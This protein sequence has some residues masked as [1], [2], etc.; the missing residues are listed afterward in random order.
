MEMA[1]TYF[2]LLTAVS[3]CICTNN[4]FAQSLWQDQENT[5]AARALEVT[6]YVNKAR[7]LR[8][9]HEAM[10]SLLL[11]TD[12]DNNIQ[13]RG[14]NSLSVE[15]PLPDGR[16][17]ILALEK[18]NLLPQELASS[19]P[20]ISTYKVAKATGDIISG[21]IDFTNKGF[22]AL[23]QTKDGETLLIDPETTGDLGQYLSYRKT[24][25][26]NHTPHQC[27][28]PA[29]QHPIQFSSLQKLTNVAAR[30]HSHSLTEYKIAI[31]ATAEYTQAQGGSVEDALSAIVTTLSRVNHIY[32]QS[33]GVRFRLVE[34]N[35][36]LIYSNS[37][38][39]PYTNFQIEN[40]LEENQTN[41]DRVIGNENY[42]I[43]HVFGTSGGGLAYISSL[44]N[45]ST[46][47]RGVSGISRPSGEFFNV[48]FVAH[49]LGHQLGATHTFNA[50]QGICTAG[51]RTSSTAFEPGSGSTIMSYAG[52]C[53]TDDVQSFA[54]AMFHSGNIEQIRQNITNGVGSVCGIEITQDNE[55]PTVFAGNSHIIPAN[56]P[57][58]LTAIA[59][60]LNNDPLTYSWD[61]KDAGDSSA[62]DFD[63]GNNALFRVLPATTNPSRSFPSLTTLLGGL[64]VTGETLPSTDRTMNFQVAVYD[65]HNAA[66][67]D[68]LQLEVI[69]TGKSFSLENIEEAYATGAQST[70]YW[71]TANTEHSPINCTTVDL[72]LSVNNGGQFN[73]LVAQS[74]ANNG[75]ATI[76]I[77]A[78]VPNTTIGRFKLSC[79][80]NVF[81][82]ISTSAFILNSDTALVET[83]TRNTNVITNHSSASGGGS[84]T[85]LFF[86]TTLFI[87]IF[88]RQYF[89]RKAVRS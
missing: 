64:E 83:Y 73:Y 76:S 68:Q 69:N 19:Y 60:D 31:A 16:N 4:G 49:E 41:I 89:R 3:F 13:A 74:L 2:K 21:R 55:A 78:S 18:T 51:A 38:T 85:P 24:E 53:G 77:P 23:L 54:D 5:T 72:S 66:S 22:H 50:D 8:L 10:A 88:K 80:D 48:D 71:E 39:D 42:D 7:S 61:Q 70:I 15:V 34:N 82:N 20:S 57:F 28:I 45:N 87:F 30:T 43:G 17:V 9:D 33:V 29:A 26:S 47:A 52:G 81:F 25:L 67:I 35:D 58:E 44:C 40:L 27:N 62:I 59:A 75:S 6:D 65:S 56:T 86:I 32:E 14:L 79:S 37:V 11:Q 12:L 63:T 1:K 46:K 84:T 36:E